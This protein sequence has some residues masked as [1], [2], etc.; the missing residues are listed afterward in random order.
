MISNMV[1]YSSTVTDVGT[2][3]AHQFL[4]TNSVI[5][6]NLVRA[7]TDSKVRLFRQINAATTVIH[8][9][10]FEVD[11]SNTINE[12]PNARQRSA[13][14]RNLIKFK[15]LKPN[16]DGYDGSPPKDGAVF[17]AVEFLRRLPRNVKLPKEMVAG[18]GDVGLYW[19]DGKVFIELGFNGSGRYY[20]YAEDANDEASGDDLNVLSRSIP[21]DLLKRISA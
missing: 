15:Y 2:L 18:D 8:T 13:I 11:R 9:D 19:D 10:Y 4:S 16:W 12:S 1:D 21:S 17:D 14:E 5:A 20:F 7:P 3:V 6:K